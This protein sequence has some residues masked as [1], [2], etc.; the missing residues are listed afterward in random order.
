M[1][2]SNCRFDCGRGIDH[3]ESETCHACY[4]ALAYWLKQSVT[5]IAK[6]AKTLEAWERRIQFLLKPKLVRRD[7]SK[8]RRRRR[9]A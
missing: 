8:K 2:R 7:A 3:P 4:C 1:S 6:R 9:A 5:A